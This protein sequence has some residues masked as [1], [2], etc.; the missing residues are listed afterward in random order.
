MK[1]NGSN[2]VKTC[3]TDILSARKLTQ[4]GRDRTWPSSLKGL[5][6]DHQRHCTVG[7]FRSSSELYAEIKLAPYRDSS[8]LDVRGSVHHS[9]VHI[10]NATR[11][12][13][14][15]KFISYLFE[16]QHISGDTPPIIRS[17]KL[18]QQ[19]LVLHAWKVVG[20]VVAGCWQAEYALPDSIQH[21]HVHAC[22]TR[23]C[24]G[25]FRLLMMGGVSP[26]TC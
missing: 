1:E 12:N 25:S 23:G 17:L 18:S 20:P 11:C 13:H 16:A 21:L 10:K 24:W 26:E 7:I 14:V 8:L 6:T 9:I 2:W 5:A 4:I 19:P 3:P 15:S 22:K